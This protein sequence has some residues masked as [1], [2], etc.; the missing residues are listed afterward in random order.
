M[1]HL[2]FSLA[3]VSQA[4]ATDRIWQVE[5]LPLE[6]I[7][8][9]KLE[10]LP[11]ELPEITVYGRV[12]KRKRQKCKLESDESVGQLLKTYFQTIDRESHHGVSSEEAAQAA[13]T[14]RLYLGDK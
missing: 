4:H 10:D 7:P 5:E 3:L 1:I 9:V 12:P 14:L 8:V 2:L 13:E 6:P 11:V